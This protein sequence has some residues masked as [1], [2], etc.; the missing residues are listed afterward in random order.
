MLVVLLF[1]LFVVL[2]SSISSLFANLGNILSEP[3]HEPVGLLALLLD[4]KTR[5]ITLFGKLMYGFMLV[6]LLS[7]W[8]SFL[9]SGVFKKR[10]KI[11]LSGL[12]LALFLFGIYRVL[13]SEQLAATLINY[14]PVPIVLLSPALFFLNDRKPS[15]SMYLFFMGILQCAAVQLGTNNGFHGSSY[16]LIL[17]GIAALI[18][19]GSMEFPFARSK[20]AKGTKTA[21]VLFLCIT[22]GFSMGYARMA[23]VYRDEPLYFLTSKL[24]TGP[25]KGI[26]TTEQSEE[27][28]RQVTEAIKQYAPEQGN[29]VFSTAL[30]FGYLC[31]NAHAATPYTCI[32]LL[33]TD[34]I[35]KYYHGNPERRPDFIF[36]VNK[37][38]GFHNGKDIL[39]DSMA[40]FIHKGNFKRIDLPCGTIYTKQ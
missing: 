11:L 13:D 19:I 27:K 31:T 40:D 32:T 16:A 36:F 4:Y 22:M 33:G 17:S 38:Y 39:S 21:A 34:K 23:Y 6:T 37:A 24:Q 12:C 1:V 2:N 7:V 30:P 28:Y 18:Y 10:I 25:A 8:Y 20:G 3:S 29:V 14:L 35:T 5:L 26:Y 9:K 15:W